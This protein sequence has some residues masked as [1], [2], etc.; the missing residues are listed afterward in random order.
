MSKKDIEALVINN[1]NDD[2]DTEK[3][4]NEKNK[5]QKKTSKSRKEVQ[6]KEQLAQKDAEILAL[7]ARIAELE[8]EVKRLRKGKD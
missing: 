5:L 1:D 4:K 6:Y 2:S 8:G 7:K 3:E